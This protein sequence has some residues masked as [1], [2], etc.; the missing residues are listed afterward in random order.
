MWY[1]YGS[2]NKS[3]CTANASIAPNISTRP[4]K[5]TGINYSIPTSK[6]MYDKLNN[7]HVTLKVFFTAFKL[8]N[9]ALHT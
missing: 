6:E 5:F 1:N 2:D 9:T 7:S 8:L 3:L 4:R